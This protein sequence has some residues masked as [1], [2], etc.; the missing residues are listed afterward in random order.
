MKVIIT[1][2]FIPKDGNAPFKRISQILAK[3]F[4]NNLID[5]KETHIVSLNA[6][7]SRLRSTILYPFFFFQT[8][9]NCF[10]LL[11]KFETD[12]F[13]IIYFYGRNLSL[14]IPVYFFAR[15]SKKFI[16][17]TDHVE[18][19][20]YLYGWKALLTNL[21]ID[22][23]IG[24]PFVWWLSNI[25]LYINKSFE[26]SRFFEE[27]RTVYFPI[28]INRSSKSI[29]KITNPTKMFFAISTLS[30]R[31]APEILKSFIT[32]IKDNGLIT[33]HILGR[34][35]NPELMSFLRKFSFVSLHNNADE[36]L[37]NELLEKSDYFI[38]FRNFRKAEFYSSPTRLAE[39]LEYNKP[40]LVNQSSFVKEV[41]GS[42]NNGYFQYQL[43]HT[44]Q[45]V[46][47]GLDNTCP[48]NLDTYFEEF[49]NSLN[50]L[51]KLIDEN[52]KSNI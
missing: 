25:N 2:N 37:K 49:N 10:M 52:K 36:Q 15:K 17:I 16:L 20:V 28:I 1:G 3:L 19:P 39:F 48:F 7:L 51:K 22:Q 8:V 38:L 34:F 23:L 5:A 26:K 18:H 47:V 33:V 21:K 40:I 27:Q 29:E 30:N 44:I 31:D 13:T 42:S 32:S 14:L 50:K 11:S 41:I 6:S 4:E 45:E 35:K 12:E 24:Y 43:N 46:M 9:R